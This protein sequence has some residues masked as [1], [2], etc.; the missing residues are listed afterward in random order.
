MDSHP[1]LLVL[2]GTLGAVV[3]TGFLNLA[4]TLI[5]KRSEERKHYRELVIKFGLEH[6][7]QR[8]E[9]VFK[10]E[11]GV[12]WPIDAHMLQF[13]KFFD[14]MLDHK[15]DESELESAY[16][17]YDRVVQKIQN[18]VRL[19]TATRQGPPQESDTAAQGQD[20][21]ALGQQSI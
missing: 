19:N 14:I 1:A 11:G 7:K 6:W 20:K 17:E 3:I 21:G 16:A 9:H 10:M 5:A 12:L 8:A 13:I 18:I 2:I 4:I 15:L